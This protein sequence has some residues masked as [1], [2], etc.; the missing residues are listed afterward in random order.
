MTAISSYS[1]SAYDSRR[2]PNQPPQIRNHAGL[3]CIRLPWGNTE[4]V[5][6]LAFIDEDS[7]H[8]LREQEELERNRPGTRERNEAKFHNACNHIGY[9]RAHAS[10]W[11]HL[12]AYMWGGGRF[13]FWILLVFWTASYLIT[14]PLIDNNWEESIESYSTFVVPWF[15]APALGSWFFGYIAIHHLPSEW[16]FKPSKGPLWELNRQTGMVTVFAHKPGQFKQCGI[17]GNFVRPFHE[18]DAHVH[19]LPSRQGMPL[20]S[21]HLVHRYH[22][23]AIDFMPVIGRQSSDSDSLALWDMWQNYMDTSRPLPDIPTWEEFRPLDPVTAEHDRNT[24]CAPRYWRDMDDATYKLALDQMSQ[25]VRALKT[26]SRPNLMA[27]HV[28]YL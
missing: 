11:T 19:T 27:R 4:D 22:P 17:D 2:I 25:R 14:T 23:V 16:I 18:F 3:L 20:Y 24:G 1:D 26:L 13:A 21:L 12:W 10:A 9:R 8:S 28:H 7:P 5:A 6:P 15:L